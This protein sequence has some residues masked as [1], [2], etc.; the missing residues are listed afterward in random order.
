MR[1]DTGG[2]DIGAWLPPLVD[3]GS[4]TSGLPA[5]AHR[6]RVLSLACMLS[7]GGLFAVAGSPFTRSTGAQTLIAVVGALAA[8][9]GISLFIWRRSVR[10]AVLH[11][12]L[13]SGAFMIAVIVG[14]TDNLAAVG[15]GASFVVWVAVYSACFLTGQQAVIQ[16]GLAL[17]MLFAAVLWA[18]PTDVVVVVGAGT[19]N[20]VVVTLCICW[21]SV[22]LRRSATTDALTG[23]ANTAAWREVMDAEVN[24]ADR[25]GHPLTV[26]FVDVDGL[27]EVN[28]GAGH[29]AGDR[30]IA[31]VAHTLRD[32]VRSTDTVARIGGDEFVVALP[33]TTAESATELMQR[34]S[35]STPV[36]FS[37]GLAQRVEGEGSD[38]LVTRADQEMYR[39]KRLRRRS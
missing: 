34:I 24:R 30:L 12:G 1:N 17:V 33:D 31:T 7:V 9:F 23:L 39:Q 32:G 4:G 21:L 38:A 28:D 26:A 29:A 14:S 18:H 37:V 10:E 27:K 19:V 25:F 22:Q 35:S 2:S 3:R 6:L 36:R 13:F 16:V 8:V 5:A 20:C 15:A 11:V